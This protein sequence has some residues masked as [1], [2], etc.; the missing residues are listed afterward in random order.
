MK[1]Y[2]S[3]GPNPRF[4]QMFIAEKG[5]NIEEQAVDLMSGENRQDAYLAKNPAGQIPA[6]ELDNGTII[7]ETTAICEYIEETSPTT[8]L[9]GT[10]AEERAETRMWTRRIDLKICEPLGTGFRSAEGAPIFQDRMRLVPEGA[11]S[12]KAIAQDGVTWLNEQLEG[13]EFIAGD[14]LTMADLKLFCF[15]DFG[16]SVGQPLDPENANV[17]AWYE[18]IKQRPSAG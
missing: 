8:P 13:K 1:L 4:V 11:D 5:L 6:L 17:L 14:R 16:N 9:V 15:L 7:S 12:L 10:T 18:R 3:M 2:T